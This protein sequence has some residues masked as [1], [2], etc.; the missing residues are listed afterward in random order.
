MR[1]IVVVAA[2]AALSGC[3]TLGRVAPSGESLTGTWH[4]GPTAMHGPGFDLSVS[5]QTINRADGSYTSLTTSE[6]TRHGESPVVMR[7]RASGSWRLEG[8][9]L[10]ST[11]RQVEFLSSSDPSIGN[12]LG[13]KMQD[14]LIRQKSVYR[15]RILAF[16]GD[17]LR[18]VPL[19]AKYKEAEVESVC[20]R[21]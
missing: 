5:T 13:Q 6:I 18:V 3:V 20:K 11:V 17:A 16:A 7:D 8:D 2:G 1:W 12:E 14:D 21:I 19:G 10:I 15:S 9:I 4:C